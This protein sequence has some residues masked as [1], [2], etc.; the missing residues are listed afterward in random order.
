MKILFDISHLLNSTGGGIHYYLKGLIP[1]LQAEC[2]QNQS[3]L[4]FLNLFFRNKL[5]QIPN[6]VNKNNLFQIC[7]PVRLIN[8]LWTKFNFPD[9]A[10][11]YKDIDVFHSPHFSLPVFSYAKKVLTVHDITY[12]KHPEFYDPA[13]KKLNDYGYRQL[14][15]FNL[16]RADHIIAISNHTKKDLIEYFS[17]EPERISVIYTGVDQCREISTEDTQLYLDEL[18]IYA[19]EYVYFPVGTVEPRKNISRTIE[20]FNNSGICKKFK[21]VISGVGSIARISEV[22]CERIKFTQ[23]NLLQE[24]DILYQNAGF[25]CYP[26]LYEGFGMPVIEAMSYG[27]AVITSK[28]T[29]LGEIAEGFAL[30]VN[31]ESADEITDA[32][33][34]LAEPQH[35]LEFEKKSLIRAK[36]F[37]WDKMAVETYKVYEELL[38]K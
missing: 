36:D 12:L 20:A 16:K 28:T 21:L 8:H 37:S 18:G 7:F 10:R 14:L 35:I 33:N 27:K 3:E 4:F 30:T 32:F 6:F 24:R 2:D 5:R 38:G 34:L 23:W 26:S 11:F 15:P 1:E 13:F 25:V 9:L 29:S 19:G 17:I 31:P 22:N